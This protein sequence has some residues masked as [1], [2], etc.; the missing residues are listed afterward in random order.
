MSLY[1]HVAS[2]DELQVFMMDAAVGEAPPVDPAEDWRAGLVRW[3]R[4]LRAVYFRHPWI[5]HIPMTGPPLEP[6]QLAWVE[7]ALRMLD[8]TGLRPDEKMAVALTILSFARG[9]AQL[10]LSLLEARRRAGITEK[11]MDERYA[12]TLRSLLDADRFPA[13][14]AV[15]EAAEPGADDQFTFG[16][17]RVLDGVEALIR[18][19]SPAQP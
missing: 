17:E 10:S 8:P 12:R 2:K 3:T 14:T 5:L 13:L 1:R 7:S 6:G 9:D 18:S 16:L 4:E 11:E 15:F 19:R